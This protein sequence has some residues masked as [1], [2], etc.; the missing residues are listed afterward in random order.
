MRQS[1]GTHSNRNG[2][3]ECTGPVALTHGA[4]CG[5]VELLHL[6]ASTFRLLL[7]CFGQLRFEVS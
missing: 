5:F 7:L 4:D 2:A 1:F 3:R 6:P